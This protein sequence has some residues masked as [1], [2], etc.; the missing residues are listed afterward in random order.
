MSDHKTQKLTKADAE[1]TLRSIKAQFVFP[2]HL[3]NIPKVI[4]MLRLYF[5]LYPHIVYVDLNIFAQ[6]RFKHPGH[7]PL[8]SRPCI[9][10]F[11]MHHFVMIIPSRHNESSFLLIS[12]ESIQEAH[13]RMAYN[14]IH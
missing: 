8:I 14:C 10:Q 12:L 9:L 2:Q 3:K 1:R 5:S 4:Y 6:L 11:K 13:L 7:H